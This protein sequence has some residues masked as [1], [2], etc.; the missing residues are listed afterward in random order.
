MLLNKKYFEVVLIIV[1]AQWC[2]GL[3]AQKKTAFIY[4]NENNSARVQFG[5][6]KVKN[7]LSQN[8]QSPSKSH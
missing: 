4:T 7:A 3:Y 2:T 6:D 8:E 5:I 1:A